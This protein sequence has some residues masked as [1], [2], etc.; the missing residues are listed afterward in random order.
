MLYTEPYLN[1]D[2]IDICPEPSTTNFVL[3]LGFPCF[4]Q[5]HFFSF[6][7]FSLGAHTTKIEYILFQYIYLSYF[8]SLA[9]HTIVIISVR[10][11]A[12]RIP[13]NRSHTPL[14]QKNIYTPNYVQFFFFFLSP[15]KQ[16]GHQL[17]CPFISNLP[18]W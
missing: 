9:I 10:R 11:G 14:Q 13:W 16:Q 8:I 12:Y 5:L 3:I 17:R 2:K 6:I 4:D 15:G 7:N 1:T 18:V